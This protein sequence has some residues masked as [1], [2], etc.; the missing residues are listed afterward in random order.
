MD[1]ITLAGEWIAKWWLD[2]LTACGLML[3]VWGWYLYINARMER[4]PLVAA[5]LNK[6]QERARGS[7]ATAR[8]IEGA[9]N[10]CGRCAGN[11][12]S[13]LRHCDRGCSR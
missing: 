3:G 11:C 10:R 7:E 1:L 8:A 4:L 6:G 2:L 5:A 13:G 9:E 12:K